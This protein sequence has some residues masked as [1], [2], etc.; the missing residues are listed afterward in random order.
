MYNPYQLTGKTILVTGASSGIGRATAIECSKLGAK[1]VI[2]A[3]NEV[4]L[5]ETLD[6]LEGCDHQMVV[7]DLTNSPDMEN[8]VA[9]IPELDGLVNDAGIAVMKPVPFIKQR[10]LEEVVN[11]N[12]FAPVLL[13][14]AILKKKKLKRNASVVMV[15]SVASM[16]SF[17]LG[18]SIY[19]LS[20]AAI[21][22][23]AE[24]CA[25]EVKNKEIRVNSVHPGM[26]ATA[27][28]QNT[29]LSATGEMDF[30]KYIMNRC[31]KPEEIAWAIAYLLSDATRWMT[32]SQLVIDGGAHLT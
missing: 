2:T 28:T 13:T 25:M 17:E 30:S 21:K 12:T 4:R 26:V 23:F 15:S 16:A 22:T 9:A 5:K 20:K 3:R 24:Y 31:G 29:S 19:G 6:A 10:D 14:G 27:M 7:A 18:N 8:L 11:I 1:L 32:G